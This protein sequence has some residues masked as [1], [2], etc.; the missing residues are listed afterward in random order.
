MCFRSVD[1]RANYEEF[2]L[3]RISKT[4]ESMKSKSLDFVI[5]YKKL[6]DVGNW[7]CTE[8]VTQIAAVGE[9]FLDG[10]VHE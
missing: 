5:F 9:M 1:E 10:L 3:L 2:K 7:M 6:I 4:P 8:S